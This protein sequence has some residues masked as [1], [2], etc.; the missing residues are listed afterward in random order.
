[1]SIQPH[2]KTFLLI[3]LA[4][5]LPVGVAKLFLSQEWYQGGV[6]NHGQLI[7]AQSYQDMALENPSPGKWQLVYAHPE[8]CL[9]VC[10]A[11]LTLLANSITALGR[12][13]ERVEPVVLVP[14]AMAPQTRQTLRDSGFILAEHPAQMPIGL[15]DSAIVDPL[16]NWVLS[17]DQQGLK[18]EQARNSRERFLDVKKLLKMSK[19][20]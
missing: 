13:N 3:V 9:Q 1:M 8:Q 16:G 10:Q 15:G 20:G 19:V 4:F 6:T 14:S 5:L 12:L 7:E 18:S 17:Y 2:Q 11:D